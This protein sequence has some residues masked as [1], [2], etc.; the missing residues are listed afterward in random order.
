MKS[1]KFYP[2]GVIQCHIRTSFRT[3]T[4]DFVIIMPTSFILLYQLIPWKG[5]LPQ[6]LALLKRKLLADMD[7]DFVGDCRP[8]IVS[9]LAEE[10]I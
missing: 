4:T 9:G 7:E 5:H 1:L 10:D 8:L 3:I 2:E 6:L